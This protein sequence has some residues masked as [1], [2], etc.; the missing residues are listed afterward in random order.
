MPDIFFQKEI[1]SNQSWEPQGVS[2][3][4]S[5]LNIWLGRQLLISYEYA[6]L[7]L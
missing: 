4:Q 7:F 6:S 1:R 2:Y 3:G 5:H